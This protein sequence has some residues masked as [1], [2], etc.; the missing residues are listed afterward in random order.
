MRRALCAVAALAA[1]FCAPLTM[2]G[3]DLPA[4]SAERDHH[5]TTALYQHEQGTNV[6]QVDYRYG[7]YRSPYYR[8]GYRYPSYGYRYGYRYPSYGYYRPYYGYRYP[9]YGYRYGYGYPYGSGYRYGYRPGF[10]FGFRF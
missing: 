7:Y 2:R 9:S 4:P 6:Q 1:I 3:S 8:Y 10:S 5:V